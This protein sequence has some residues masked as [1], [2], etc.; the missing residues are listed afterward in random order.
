MYKHIAFLKIKKSG[1]KL[2]PQFLGVCC[3]LARKILWGD[4]IPLKEMSL[5]QDPNP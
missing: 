1:C 5:V 2:T 4:M 3:N